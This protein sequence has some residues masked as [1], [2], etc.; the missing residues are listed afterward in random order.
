MPKYKL[1]DRKLQHG[2]NNKVYLRTFLDRLQTFND[3]KT[4]I[5][6]FQC[7]NFNLSIK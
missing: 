5:V 7:C 1:L 3:R 6:L 4:T 2:H